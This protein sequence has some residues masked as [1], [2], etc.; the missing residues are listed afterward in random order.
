MYVSGEPAAYVPVFPPSLCAC[1][2]VTVVVSVSSSHGRFASSEAN[3]T[4]SAT[5]VWVRRNSCAGCE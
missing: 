1:G 2:P 4:Y 3:Q 5:V